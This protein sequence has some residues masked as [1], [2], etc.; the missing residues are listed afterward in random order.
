MFKCAVWIINVICHNEKCTSFIS[1]NA[2]IYSW[3]GYMGDCKHYKWL[4]SSEGNWWWWVCNLKVMLF[5]AKE[6][7]T[8][9]GDFWHSANV[10][11]RCLG[12]IHHM[13]AYDCVRGGVDLQLCITLTTQSMMGS[14]CL[15]VEFVWSS[16]NS[17]NNDRINRQKRPPSQK[18]QNALP[19]LHIPA[20]I[21]FL[22]SSDKFTDLHLA[23]NKNI[24]SWYLHSTI[25]DRQQDTWRSLKPV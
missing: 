14:L 7:Y 11:G 22:L 21:Q 3:G 16:E 18:L 10:V 19:T 12:Y 8:C 25:K 5:W 24:L 6:A 9:V 17:I 23:T 20:D 13:S 2:D 4:H 15:Q 1:G